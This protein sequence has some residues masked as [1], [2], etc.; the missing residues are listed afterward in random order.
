MSL[1]LWYFFCLIK[2]CDEDC[3]S[4]EEIVRKGVEY[5]KKDLINEIQR[6]KKSM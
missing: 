5:S 2:S 1:R 3:D 6:R 4:T